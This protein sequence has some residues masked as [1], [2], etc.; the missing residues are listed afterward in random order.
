MAAK[1]LLSHG[2][3]WRIGDGTSIKV[4]GDN[5]LPN[6]GS[7]TFHSGLSLPCDAKVANLINVSVKGW[8]YALI[9]NSFS[10]Y[11]AN[12][13]KN[14]SLCRSLPPDKII[15]NG[16][17]NGVFS[18]KSAYHIALDLLRRKNGECSSSSGS[19]EFWKKI[20]AVKAPNALKKFLWRACQ[21]VL[22]TKQNLLRKGVV[23]NDLCPC[24]Q[25]E[26]SL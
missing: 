15:W 23:D 25:L 9:D 13:I 14:I 2:I 20:W 18:V 26:W 12:I 19:S 21:N 16:T 22:P 7:L 3:I 5:W 17:L 11:V 1:G 6:I 8:N 10:A 4:W 24:C